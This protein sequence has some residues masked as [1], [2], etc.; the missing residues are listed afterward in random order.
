[1][2][3]GTNFPHFFVCDL[4]LNYSD[5][6]VQHNA[7]C[8]AK[9]PWL[10][11]KHPLLLLPCIMATSRQLLS[12]LHPCT[13]AL[14]LAFVPSILRDLCDFA[15]QIVNLNGEKETIL[16][17]PSRCGGQQY[18]LLVLCAYLFFLSSSGRE[19]LTSQVRWW[20]FG[21]ARRDQKDF[22]FSFWTSWMF[23]TARPDTCWHWLSSAGVLALLQILQITTGSDCWSQHLGTEVH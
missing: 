20:N 7:N 13:S 3:A 2:L 4:G 12:C 14:L 8:P 5:P 9:P 17:K 15:E 1:M 18:D 6:S 23:F 11:S 19:C 10:N 21:N 16:H 22:C